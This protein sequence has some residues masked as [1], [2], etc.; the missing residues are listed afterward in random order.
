MKN[1]TILFLFTILFSLFSCDSKDQFGF[2]LK[3]KEEL[4]L[5]NHI[6]TYNNL[7]IKLNDQQFSYLKSIENNL[8][9][10]QATLDDPEKETYGNI[11][12][13]LTHASFH[14]P[15]QFPNQKLEEPRDFFSEQ[16]RTFFVSNV[17]S[18]K[19]NFKNIQ[20]KYDE[21]YA[22]LKAEDFKDDTG[23]K[24]K[25]MVTEIRNLMDQFYKKNDEIAA[26]LSKLT[27]SA[28]TI[29][30][31]DHPLKDYILAFK[32]DSKAVT[33]FVDISF[34]SPENYQT[35][36][37]KLT[38]AYQKLEKLNLAHSAMKVPDNKEF[39]GRGSAFEQFNKSVN[40]FLAEARKMMRNATESGEIA[41]NDLDAL[42][43]NE[44]LIR[45][46]YNTFVD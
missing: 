11:T 4:E 2:N 28:E 19:A 30:L 8:S 5:A 24:G 37:P 16:D 34:E 9:D 27:N 23:A 14:D 12:I 1:S 21:L 7:L 39:P 31:K 46:V 44:E 32:E 43:R 45:Q 41:Q 20:T 26:K 18:L 17:T 6:I 3:E 38:A 36:E 15:I 40:E 33:E 35:I 13:G 29:I 10:I 42:T 22:Y 25:K